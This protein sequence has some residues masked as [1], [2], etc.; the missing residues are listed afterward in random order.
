MSS[1][2]RV[3]LRVCYGEKP[4]MMFFAMLLM[5]CGA[6]ENLH[7]PPSS[8]SVST[9]GWVVG[10][11]LP[12]AVCLESVGDTGPPVRMTARL[13]VVLRGALTGDCPGSSGVRGGDEGAAEGALP[14]NVGSEKGQTEELCLVMLAVL[15][16]R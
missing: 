7:L 8:C 6:P 1:I 16:A 5:G 10:L 9:A 3:V 2:G 15:E 4:V 11:S 12:C 13:A 14:G